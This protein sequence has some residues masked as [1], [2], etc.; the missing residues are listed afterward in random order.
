MTDTHL[1]HFTAENVSKIEFIK[2]AKIYVITVE[3]NGETI[4]YTYRIDD[5]MF[6][7]VDGL[8]KSYY[9]RMEYV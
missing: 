9:E 3:L 6:K 1:L 4:K 5:N 8:I 7:Y 2:S